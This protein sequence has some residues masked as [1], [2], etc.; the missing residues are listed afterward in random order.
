MVPRMTWTP[1]RTDRSGERGGRTS[2]LPKPIADYLV[3]HKKVKAV[4]YPGLENH[5]QHEL[6]KKRS[7]E[8]TS[9]LQ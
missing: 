1:T 4:F 6:A 3:R 8:H 5:P 7:E 2:L 9:E